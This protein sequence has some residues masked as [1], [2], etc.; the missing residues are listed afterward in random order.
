MSRKQIKEP[1]FGI[2]LRGVEQNVVTSL[3]M[4]ESVLSFPGASIIPMVNHTLKNVFGDRSAIRN[5]NPASRRELDQ[6]SHNLLTRE[7][8]KAE[9]IAPVIRLIKQETPNMVTFCRSPVDQAPWERG[10]EVT[11]SDDESDLFCE[12]DLFTLIRSFVGHTTTSAFMGQALFDAFPE[13]LDDL[14]TLDEQSAIL[15]IGAPRWLS[16]PWVSAACAARD[17]LLYTLA[18]FHDAFAA[19]DDG[20]DPG[21]EFRDFDDVSE[22]VKQQIRIFRNQGLSKHASAP[23]HLSL[24]WAMNAQASNSVF[25]HVL[26]IFADRKLL[27]DV[28]KEIAP[29]AKSS[30]PSGEETGFPF[31]ELPRLSIDTE[32][33]YSSC[34]LLRASYYETARLDS[35]QLSFRK[36]TSDLTITESNEDARDAGMSRPRTYQLEKTD[37]VAIPHGIFH[38]DAE[39]FSNPDQYDPLRFIRTDE[40]GVKK[41]YMHAINT[42]ASLL[43]CDGSAP[44]REILA[45][46]AAILAMWNIEPASEGGFM[47]PEHKPTSVAPMPKTDIRVKLR[48]RV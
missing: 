12:T 24:L 25:W 18:V 3:S 14:R 46:T 4:A 38:R 30:R 11:V 40:T 8:N 6:N 36:L 21:A 15:S 5:L 20:A 23:G 28:R 33:L 27:E 44:E 7:S 32:G 13:L 42:S 29:Y 2:V 34:P 41:A 1:V 35:A 10:C 9:G 26:R 22:P 45:F 48:A 37:N 39:R 16:F 31:Q 17:R 47:I 19:W 43:G